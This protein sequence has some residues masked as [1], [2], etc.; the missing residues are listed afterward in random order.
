M[1]KQRI[2]KLNIKILKKILFIPIFLVSLINFWSAEEWLVFTVEWTWTSFSISNFCRPTG[3]NGNSI[4]WFSQVNIKISGNSITTGYWRKC[5]EMYGPV[6]S[7][8][9]SYRING[10]RNY[11]NNSRRKSISLYNLDQISES[12][13][14]EI[15]WSDNDNITVNWNSIT[16]YGN[17]TLVCDIIF[18]NNWP[19]TITIEDPLY[20]TENYQSWQITNIKVWSTGSYITKKWENEELIEITHNYSSGNITA[21]NQVKWL[22]K[23]ES[24]DLSNNKISDISFLKNQYDWKSLRFLDL[25]NNKINSIG[26][27]TFNNITTL[28]KL[29]LSKNNINE[30]SNW[31]FNWLSNLKE[32]DLSENY[33]SYITHN[34]STLTNITWL[35]L[36][37]QKGS[38][39]NIESYAFNW[40][41]NLEILSLQDNQIQELKW[42]TF[43]WLPNVKNLNLQ[44]NKISNITNSETLYPFDDFGTNSQENINI[45][46][47]GNSLTGISYSLRKIFS[48]FHTFLDFGNNQSFYTNNKS[49]KILTLNLTNNKIN[50]VQ[51]EKNN[52]IIVGPN[53]FKR[54][55]ASQTLTNPTYRRIIT[56]TKNNTTFL[57]WEWKDK[58][59]NNIN[60]NE[61]FKWKLR[62]Y[63]TDSIFDDLN[64]STNI[65]S[66]IDI[67]A[68]D[69][70]IENLN[71]F[72]TYRN[73]NFKIK[74]NTN[75]EDIYNKYEIEKGWQIYD[76]GIFSWKEFEKTIFFENGEYTISA[77]MF[78][79]NDNEITSNTWNSFTVNI[80]YTWKHR[81]KINYPTKESFNSGDTKINSI[82]REYRRWYL[83]N[84]TC[85]EDAWYID[86]LWYITWFIYE[87]NDSN[88]QNY[89]SWFKKTNPKPS[90]GCRSSWYNIQNINLE[91]WSWRYYVNVKIIDLNWNIIKTLTWT[92]FDIGKVHTVTIK[93]NTTQYLYVWDWKLIKEPENPTKDWY[94]FSWWYT[95]QSCTNKYNF[96]SP[97][98]QNLT[99]YPKRERDPTLPQQYKLIIYYQKSEWWTASTAKTLYITGWYEYSVVSP[100]VTNY[101]PNLTTVSWIMPYEDKTVTVIYTK[102]ESWGWWW[103]VWGWWTVSSNTYTLTIYYKYS[104]WWNASSTHTESVKAWNSYSVSSPYISN[105]TP[106][107]TVVEWTMPS[108]NKT[109]YVYYTKNKSN[110]LTVNASNRYPSTNEWIN[111]NIGTDSNYTEKINFSKLQYR[112]STSSSWSNIPRT[113]TTYVSD[114]SYDWSAGYYRMTRSDYGYATI[115]NLIKFKRSGYYRIYITDAY[116]NEAYVDINVDET[117]ENWNTESDLSLST[118][119]NNPD[120]YEPISITLKTDNYIGKLKLYA[121]YKDS[122]NSRVKVSNT[123]TTY[124]SDYSNIWE[125]WY[126][127]MVSS[128]KWK[129][130][131]SDLVTFKKDWSY[132]IY[133]E[134][135]KWY[136]NY[137]QINVDASDESTANSKTNQNNTK[138]YDIESVLQSLLNKDINSNTWSASPESAIENLLKSTQTTT[139]TTEETY[140]TRSCKQ[141]KLQYN[142]NLKAFTSPDM[143]KSEYFIN[144]DYLKRYLDSKNPQKSN[145][146]INSWWISTPYSDSTNSSDSF[147]APNGKVYSISNQNWSYSSSNFTSNKS[148]ATLAEIKNFIKNR[149]PLIWM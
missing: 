103:G 56:D 88:W 120:K 30:I 97:V 147:T 46:L 72:V 52:N 15:F 1:I 73:I 119:N 80:P 16:N 109:V 118:N 7:N 63:I 104:D 44:N 28:K 146:P 31:D 95:D 25:S 13:H 116:G 54:L 93:N 5:E 98:T 74:W 141:Y 50:Y 69:N 45:N 107:Y 142:S 113:S 11:N 100:T 117:N 82:S 75:K 79:S 127:N 26:N 51:I 122:S 47:S 9:G 102:N 64:I 134:D 135:E 145:C 55:W 62:V 60:L 110:Y 6:P 70:N 140:T 42:C 108:Y 131:L 34:F 149:N 43:C 123:S 21:V 57:T 86:Y 138:D 96:D 78:D 20:S 143:K 148:F 53:T 68:N 22:P 115:N 99:L 89:Y 19:H 24:L 136:L 59:I 81:S 71:N 130:T 27:S 91:P 90:D 112:S 4:N 36:Q 77:R 129:K 85:K 83:E 105:Y 126:Y 66:S 101:T 114:Y 2:K 37:W 41:N 23:L 92:N 40:L 137:I 12:S 144:K 106:N 139:D 65:I 38:T 111:L 39:L 94:I 128:D 61:D 35:Y 124:F 49:G 76:S 121:K 125:L 58:E 10:E 14:C 33:I 133:A 48:S 84:D 18:K 17:N 32:L 67:L 87:I 29:N 8:V 3:A 132:R